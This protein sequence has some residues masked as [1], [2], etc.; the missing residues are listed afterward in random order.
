MNVDRARRIDSP[1]AAGP[2]ASPLATRLVE[3]PMALAS[4]PDGTQ[5]ED[6]GADIGAVPRGL[7]MLRPRPGPHRQHLGH[8]RAGLLPLRGGLRRRQR[9]GVVGFTR[10]LRSY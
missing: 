6:R 4:V 1:G 3:H 9:G 8:G 7:G 10:V 2:A 5:D